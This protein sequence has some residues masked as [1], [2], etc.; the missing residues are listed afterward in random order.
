MK[1]W[2]LVIWALWS[3]NTLA[4]SVTEGKASYYADSLHGHITANGQYY[5]K[6]A[7]TAA[8]KTLAFG[9]RVKVTNLSNKK[10]VVVVVNDR[11]PFVRNRIIDLS[12]AAAKRLGMIDRG[13]TRVRL[14]I[15]K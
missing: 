13:V 1:T 8:H 2:A 14:E 15:I 6:N 7:L 4:A 9:T 12:R 11:G 5:D 3:V 10:S